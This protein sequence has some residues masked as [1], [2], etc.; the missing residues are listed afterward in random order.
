[1]GPSQLME[2]AA[3]SLLCANCGLD[4][5]C[6][7]KTGKYATAPTG[8]RPLH[9]LLLMNAGH[10][11]NEVPFLREGHLTVGTGK[12]TLSCVVRHVVP[13]GVSV[14][15]GR[16]A[17]GTEKRTLPRVGAYVVLEDVFPSKCRRTQV[18][19][20]RALARV[21]PEVR[22]HVASDK[23]HICAHPAEKQMALRGHE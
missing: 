15:K 23:G 1:M 10:V 11:E 4:L 7:R 17:V 22:D 3:L 21:S 12:A 19:Q 18:A 16:V 20:K 14:Q 8:W 5:K 9:L 6:P 13:E 2:K